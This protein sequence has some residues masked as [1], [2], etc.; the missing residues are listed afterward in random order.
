MELFRFLEYSTAIAGIV[1][2]II[3]VKIFMKFI[4][5]H[6]GSSTKAQTRLADMIESMLRF[7]ERNNK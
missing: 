5:N 2:I 1:G 3:V 4:G 6:I 7:L